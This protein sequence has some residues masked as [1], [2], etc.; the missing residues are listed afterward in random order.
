VTR[1]GPLAPFARRIEDVAW[2][3]GDVERRCDVLVIG[4]GI[5]GTAAALVAARGNARVVLLDAGTGSST[6]STGAVD[7]TPWQAR[8][9]G[10]SSGR[11]APIGAPVRLVMAALG[12]AY[13]VPDA[14]ARLPTTGGVVREARGHDAALIDVGPLAGRRIAVV[15]CLRP[16]WDATALAAAWGHGYEAVD[17]VVSRHVDERWLPDADFA[18]RHDDDERLGWL[19]QRLREA[20]A[21]AGGDFA[22]L[23]VPPCLGIESARAAALSGALGLPSG[24]PVGAPGGPSGLRFERARDR[25]IDAA[26]VLCLR[27]RASEVAPLAGEGVLWR[28]S[29]EGQGQAGGSGPTSVVAASVVLA[30]GGL[31]GGGIEYAPAESVFASA[32]PP[33]ALP[34]FRLA[35][36]APV[37]LGAFARPLDLPST[38]FGIPPEAIA[39]PF[40]RDALMD[41]V[42][43][44]ADAG[45]RCAAGLFAAGDLLADRPRTW[46][47][48]AATGASAGAA[49][50]ANALT[51]AAL[52]AASHAAGPPSRP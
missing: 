46:L 24:E 27:A 21:R 2:Q 42:G 31:V 7:A 6:L 33:F 22:G 17:A 32:L 36:R 38:L 18:M 9:P 26:G 49:S 4:A 29:L 39:W 37:S 44:V 11:P 1:S 41:H 20:L 51:A 28:V 19:A 12:G 3:Q 16:D 14:G 47:D 45:A 34:P 23:V 25:A 8:A 30:M 5:A 48:A 52:P 43:V 13:A 50:A 10:A 35:V 40:V 15:R